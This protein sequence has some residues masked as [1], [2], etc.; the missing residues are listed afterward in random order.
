MN[1][2]KREILRYMCVRQSECDDKTEAI[3]DEMTLKVLDSVSPKFI[4]KEYSLECDKDNILIG[5]NNG[6]NIHSTN[7]SLNLKGCDRV[8]LFA[9]TLGTQADTLVRRYE[10]ASMV[11]AAAAQAICTEVIEAYCNEVIDNIR[12]SLLEKGYYLRPR[13]SAGYGDFALSHQTDFFRMLDIT[14]LLGVNLNNELLMIP[15]KSITAVIGVTRDS[16]NCSI[17]KC[18]NCSKKDC[19][20]RDEF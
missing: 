17:E 10:A 4:Y 6:M 18:R 11:R 3:V 8:L 5:G 20:F 9:A 16:K 13:F 15:T 2:R 7:L 12:L 1:I 14:K 19:E